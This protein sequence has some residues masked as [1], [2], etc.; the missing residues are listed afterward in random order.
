M[1]PAEADVE[2]VIDEEDTFE[3]LFQEEMMM[4]EVVNLEEPGR[5]R[6]ISQGILL[7]LRQRK[8]K[9][10]MQRICRSGHGARRA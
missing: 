10:M 8:G 9:G 4:E 1:P 6:L 5:R 3:K 2:V 7:T